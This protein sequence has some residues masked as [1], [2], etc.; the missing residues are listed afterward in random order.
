VLIRTHATLISAGTERMLV[1]FGKANLIGKAR[2]QPDKVRMVVD[3]VRTDGLAP[4]LDAVCNKLA[5]PLPFGYCNVGEILEV[6]RGVEGFAVGD[7]VASNGEHAEVRSVPKNLGARFPEC[8][9]LLHDVFGD[10][11]FDSEGVHLS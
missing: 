6:G 10:H 9:C 7:R 11:D 1:D 8:W 4:T 3:K 5:Q 2:Q